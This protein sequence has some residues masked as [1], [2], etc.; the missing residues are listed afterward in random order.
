MKDLTEIVLKAVKFDRT[1]FSRVDKD[2]KVLSGVPIIYLLFALAA[3]IG[4]VGKLGVF[5][6]VAGTIGA[7]IRWAVLF[8]I[9]YLISKKYGTLGREDDFLDTVKYFGLAVSPGILRIVGFL[10]GFYKPVF[11]I[12]TLWMLGITAF[13]LNELFDLNDMLKAGGICALSWL[14]TY[15]GAKL[16]GFSIFSF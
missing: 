8:Y 16:I 1:L 3:G 14:I 7:A 15:L 10:P 11:I 2:K 9:V 6:I 13:I 5:G 4:S 12:A